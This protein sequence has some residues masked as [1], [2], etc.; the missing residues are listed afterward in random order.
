M[1]TCRL[2]T[3]KQLNALIVKIQAH[4]DVMSE[5]GSE[6]EAEESGQILSALCELKQYRA[7]ATQEMK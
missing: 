4:S 3:D 2:L 7:L 1:M 6:Q 5:L